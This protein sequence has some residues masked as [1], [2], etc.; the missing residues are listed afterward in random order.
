MFQKKSHVQF[1]RFTASLFAT[2]SFGFYHVVF[3]SESLFLF[4]Y[5]V[6]IA[7]LFEHTL[8]QK[9]SIIDMPI[10]KLTALSIFLASN[11]FV[12]STGFFA[13]AH[14][15]YPLLADIL[16]SFTSKHKLL[17]KERQFTNWKVIKSLLAIA[18]IS[19]LFL[20]PFGWIIKKNHSEYCSGSSSQ[21]LSNLKTS[22]NFGYMC[23]NTFRTSVQ[24]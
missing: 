8:V 1:C 7:I 9:K 14:I 10:K 12:R 19:A 21:A 5:S 16:R 6:G 2:C 24:F 4:I 20:F 11:G 13:A 23:K 18:V 17:P 22:V 15:C 3:Y